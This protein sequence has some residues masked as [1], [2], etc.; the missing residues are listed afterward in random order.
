MLGRG[1]EP[2]L[3][4]PGLTQ[5]DRAGRAQEPH[6]RP[7]GRPRI[8]RIGIA[9]VARRQA[10]DIGVVFHR[11][12]HPGEEAGIGTRVESRVDRLG[13]ASRTRFVPYL[14]GIEGYVE[15]M[16]PL[17]RGVDNLGGADPPRPDRLGETDRVEVGHRV[18]GKGVHHAHGFE[19]RPGILPPRIRSVPSPSVPQRRIPAAASRRPTAARL[20]RSFRPPGGS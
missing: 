5:R 1:R 10:G 16:G 15:A 19:T 7:V 18:V 2:V 8:V 11:R 3:R 17:D 12:R 9:A 14:P 13:C 4:H 20:P 6:E